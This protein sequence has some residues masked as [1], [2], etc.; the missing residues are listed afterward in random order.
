L[1]HVLVIEALFLITLHV[2]R[3]ILICGKQ[4]YLEQ[5]VRDKARAEQEKSEYEVRTI[6]CRRHLSP[7]LI[8]ILSEQ[9]RWQWR[10]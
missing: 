6:C 2:E 10:G 7:V 8:R 9:E 3:V 5:A 4:P 1:T